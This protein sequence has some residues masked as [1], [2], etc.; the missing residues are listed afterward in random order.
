[1]PI[2]EQT[3]KVLYEDKNPV[4]AAKD[5]MCRSQKAEFYG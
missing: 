3:Y 5:L 2:V 1:M 4:F